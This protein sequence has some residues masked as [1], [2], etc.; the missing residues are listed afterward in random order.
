MSAQ[1]PA[2]TPGL[3]VLVVED[4][5]QQLQHLMLMVEAA[6]AEPIPSRNGIGA[7][8]MARGGGV[9]GVISDIHMP[10]LDGFQLCRLLKDDPATRAIRVL[11][12]TG[13]PGRFHG[14]WASVCGA[15]QFLEKGQTQ[16]GVVAFLKSLPPPSESRAGAGGPSLPLPDLSQVQEYLAK[17]LESKLLESGLRQAI[18]GLCKHVNAPN[19]MAFSFLHLLHELVFPGVAFIEWP[20]PAGRTLF[21]LESQGLPDHARALLEAALPEGQRRLNPPM[22]NPWPW[23]DTFELVTYPIPALGGASGRWG[24]V[25]SPELLSA[26]APHLELLQEEVT[27]VLQNILSYHQLLRSNAELRAL[28]LGRSE[29]IQV[30]A[31]EIRT[32]ITA[33]QLYLDLLG[34]KLTGRLDAEEMRGHR[35]CQASIDSLL[36]IINGVLDVERRSHGATVATPEMAVEMAPLVN[37]VVETLSLLGKRHD[38][39]VKAVLV[40]PATQSN[41]IATGDPQKITRCLMNIITNAIKYSPAHHDV[42]VLLSLQG[43][44][45]RVEIQDEGEGISSEF[46]PEIFQPF[47]QGDTLHGGSG[48]GLSITRSMIL[49]MGGQIGH[50]ARPTR[51]TA[52]WFEL[53]RYRPHDDR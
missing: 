22:S 5:P 30:L 39:H 51:G 43:D 41:L 36:G 50:Y 9:S 52:F 27:L 44:F 18:H 17:S 3:R 25:A 45:I 34:D 47:H 19:T 40:M 28:E 46:A 29:L 6:G 8:E 35:S 14:L 32:P 24:V 49:E 10:L 37:Q 42:L 48:L 13:R 26:H 23:P 33:L 53:P 31:H 1:T 4:D 16:E 12:L 7:Y 21:L 11:L 2:L 15:D 20:G 38:V